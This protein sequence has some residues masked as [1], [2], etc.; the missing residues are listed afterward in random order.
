MPNVHRQFQNY[1]EQYPNLIIIE[2]VAHGFGIADEH[3]ASIREEYPNLIIIED[4]AHGF[5]SRD[6]GKRLCGKIGDA[7]FFSLEYSKPI[8]AGLGG[9]LII[10]NQE[11]LPEFQKDFDK[12]EY[13]GIGN[14]LRKLLTLSAIVF[15][16][17][18][19]TSFFRINLMRFVRISGIGYATSVKEIEGEMPNSYP[20][21]LHPL[22]CNLLVPQLTRIEDINR[23]KN[24][25]VIE[26]RKFLSG[27]SSLLP[28]EVDDAVMI[29]YPLLF[30]DQVSNEQITAL[31]NEALGKGF[32]FGDWF[33]DVVHPKGS[34]R[35]MYQEGSCPVGEKVADRMLNLPVNAFF[36]VSERDLK[37]LVALMKKHGLN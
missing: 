8:T 31:R 21:K 20:T 14:A 33:N 5:G 4:V 23:I 34:Y 19:W 24:Q 7:S 28:I 25:I 35:Y 12:I 27:F 9:I 1:A 29:R 36:R 30:K 6:N 16:R 37:A 11:L 3:L 13:D 17:S 18:R 2:D 26:Y 15:S 10:N 22:L 32:S